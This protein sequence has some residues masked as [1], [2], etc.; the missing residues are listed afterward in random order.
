[1][2]RN[3]ILPGDDVDRRGRL[4]SPSIMLEEMTVAQ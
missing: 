1:M 4:H 2:F 3:I